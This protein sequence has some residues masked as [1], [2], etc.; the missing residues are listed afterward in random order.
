MHVGAAARTECARRAKRS[1]RRTL[2]VLAVLCEHA[3]DHFAVD[4]G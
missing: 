2:Q 4:I 1:A 3:F